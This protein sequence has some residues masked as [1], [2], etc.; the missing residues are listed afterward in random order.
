MQEHLAGEYTIL[1]NGID[2]ERFATGPATPAK[3][4]AVLFVGRHEPRKGLEVLLEAWKGIDRDA[5]LWVVGTGPQTQQLRARRV[6][7]VQWLGVISDDELARRLR[8]AVGVL[9]R[10]PLVASRSGWCCSKRWL[11]A[12]PLSSPISTATAMSR[13]PSG[14]RWSSRRGIPLPCAAPYGRCSTIRRGRLHSRTRA[15]YE[16]GEFS[17]RR[18]AEAYLEVYEKTLAL[19]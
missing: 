12:A 1:W 2:V 19:A 16:R 17:M 11:P 10:R 14:R 15:R 9:A 7:G 6:P 13:D 3:S 18:L 4:P 5:E 8:G